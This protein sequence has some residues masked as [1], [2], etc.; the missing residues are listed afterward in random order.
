[1]VVVV[2][3]VA[4]VV[5]ASGDC[6]GGG[7]G[8]GGGGGCG[9]GGGGGGGGCGGGG[10]GGG[11]VVGGGP[12]VLHLYLYSYPSI[13]QLKMLRP[14]VHLVELHPRPQ[15]QCPGTPPPRS[16]VHRFVDALLPSIQLPCHRFSPQSC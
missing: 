4:V 7:G 1:M 12:S 15:S 14:S 2:V 9:S 3:V 8:G 6:C 5:A 11:W 10:G 13:C 16:L